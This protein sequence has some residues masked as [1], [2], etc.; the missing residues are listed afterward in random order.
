[1]Y[2]LLL[3]FSV[4]MV[5]LVPSANAI[6][7]FTN[8]HNG[9]NVGFPPL[10]VPIAIYGHGGWTCQADVR[11]QKVKS[12]EPVPAMTPTG[13]VRHDRAWRSNDVRQVSN[14]QPVADAKPA[15]SPQ[16]VAA[17]RWWGRSNYGNNNGNGNG[18]SNY[19]TNGNEVRDEGGDYNST[20]S[21][22]P[23]KLKNGPTDAIDSEKATTNGNERAKSPVSVHAHPGIA[24]QKDNNAAPQPGASSRRNSNDMLRAGAPPPDGAG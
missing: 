16:Y 5:L 4:A 23:A 20:Q 24:P 15:G 8:F 18:N 13:L 19:T 12:I 2:R 17:G 7:M 14:E 3:L 6:E 21:P 11:P 9:E 1:M 10:E 22:T